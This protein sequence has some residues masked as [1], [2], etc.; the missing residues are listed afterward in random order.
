[1]GLNKFRFKSNRTVNRLNVLMTG[2]PSKVNPKDILIKI[3]KLK[4]A[5][6]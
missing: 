6:K 4:E 2:K 1:M 3:K 5:R